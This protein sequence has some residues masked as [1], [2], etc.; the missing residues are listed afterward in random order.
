MNN[1]DVSWFATASQKMNWSTARQKVI[2]ENIA[3]A[4]TPEYVGRDVTSFEDFIDQS[5]QQPG[6]SVET[7]EADNSWDG[8]F[9]GNAVVL[10]EQALLSSQTAGEFALATRLYRMGHQMITISIGKG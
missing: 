1:S 9:D 4:D 8:S 5:A 3:N 2:S 7:Q 6:K 10:E